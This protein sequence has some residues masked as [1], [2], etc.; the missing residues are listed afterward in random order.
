MQPAAHADAAASFFATRRDVVDVH[1]DVPPSSVKKGVWLG[2]PG[3]RC[4]VGTS[5]YRA[6]HAIRSAS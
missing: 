2:R 5:A 1:A 4:A 6:S 3:V